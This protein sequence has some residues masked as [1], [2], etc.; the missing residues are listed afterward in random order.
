MSVSPSNLG[1]S[2]ID[3]D[4][5]LPLQMQDDFLGGFPR[6]KVGCINRYFRILGLF[7]GIRYAGEF[8]K[9]SGPSLGIE[10]LAVALL[11]HLDRSRHMHQD[12][13]AQRLDHSTHVF[14]SSIVRSD[15]RA[16]GDASIFRDLRSHVADTADVNVAML[17]GEAEFRR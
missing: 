15:G 9:N 11:A 12:E 3:P 8:L 13:A 17:L 5:A 14:A 10:A 16:D 7:V 2:S 4:E 6:R 1:R